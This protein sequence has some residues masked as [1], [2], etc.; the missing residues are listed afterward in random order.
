MFAKLKKKIQEESQNVAGGNEEKPIKPPHPSGASA[1]VAS[2]GRKM[3]NSSPRVT[4]P[5]PNMSPHSGVTS[6]GVPS[7][8]PGLAS[9]VNTNVTG[10]LLASIHGS[11]GTNGECQHEANVDSSSL[12]LCDK[13]KE[14]ILE[15]LIRRTDQVKKLETKITELLSTV[16]EKNKEVERLEQSLVLFHSVSDPGQQQIKEN[17]GNVLDVEPEL[18]K[19]KERLRISNKNIERLQ[20]ELESIRTQL[21]TTTDRCKKLEEKNKVL[22]EKLE[23]EHSAK[24]EALSKVSQLEKDLE[25]LLHFRENC[26]VLKEKYENL[27]TES[28]LVQK[29]LQSEIETKNELCTRLQE[30][31]LKLEKRLRDCK[32]PDNDQLQALEKQ[33]ESLEQQLS[34]SQE[35]L[36]QLKMLSGHKVATLEQKVLYLNS[37][38]AEQ[39]RELS[40]SQRNLNESRNT[41]EREVESWKSKL[42]M[43]LLEVKEKNKQLETQKQNHDSEIARRQKNANLLEDELREQINQ[44]QCQLE[45]LEKARERDKQA[46]QDKIAKLETKQGEW[47]EQEIDMERQ[48]TVLEDNLHKLKMELSEKD[49]EAT[50]LRH[51]LK[52]K[53]QQLAESEQKRAEHQENTRKYEKNADKYQSSVISL[54]NE[55]HTCSKEKD[56]LLLRNAQLSQEFESYKRR[57]ISE[58]ADLQEDIKYKDRTIEKL[59][60]TLT[61]FKQKI[62]EQQEK[63][64]ELERSQSEVVDK[65]H[66]DEINQLKQQLSDMEGQL[67]DKNKTVKML[68]QRLNELKKTL[69][70]ELKV[71]S[72]PNDELSGRLTPSSSSKDLNNQVT[73]TNSLSNNHRQERSAP[74]SIAVTPQDGMDHQLTAHHHTKRSNFMHKNQNMSECNTRYP[75]IPQDALSGQRT[76]NSSLKGHYCDPKDFSY[77]INFEYLKHVVLKFLLSREH[78]AVHLIKALAM[79]L[80][81]TPDEQRL[82][83]DT[84]D[85]KMSWFGTRPQ[86]GRGQLA[87]VIP[88]SY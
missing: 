3:S 87:K 81:F 58:H 79:L 69:Q 70:R 74:A 59:E 37:K 17:S 76:Q 29:K 39:A 1:I 60:E 20:N 43:A 21:S 48:I 22:E 40:K 46:A 57:L 33:R 84:L 63:I 42:Q 77:D 86:L 26:T 30:K 24:T 19:L 75:S 38:V 47:L 25:E 78:E 13:E 83:K 41:L 67:S 64:V 14:E 4:I 31:V 52:Q 65:V 55:L 61:D 85:W 27:Q 9:P 53:Q 12:D 66:S 82:I 44:L 16:K 50:V 71:Q 68:Q 51:Q 23:E 10:V 34:E 18:N 56:D 28:E 49:R 45:T 36:S 62:S 72:L 11:K 5:Q 35:Q 15:M 2:P 88:S 73:A 80:H 8:G 6:P 54:E 7:P 32:L